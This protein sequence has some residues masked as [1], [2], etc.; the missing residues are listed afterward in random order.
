[1]GSDMV[2]ASF[3]DRRSRGSIPQPEKREKHGRRRAG[4][5]GVRS[6]PSPTKTFAS[7]RSPFTRNEADVFGILDKMKGAAGALAG[8]A[9]DA[10]GAGFETVKGILDGV[11]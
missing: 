8:H 4:R 2:G 11:V 1:M 9:T 6:S 5:I 7:D 3:A 10:Y